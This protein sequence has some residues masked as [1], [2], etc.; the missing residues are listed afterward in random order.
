AASAKGNAHQKNK[1]GVA[2]FAKGSFKEAIACFSEVEDILR[3]QGYAT[4]SEEQTRE[5]AVALVNKARSQLFSGN[6][7]EAEADALVAARVDVN[8]CKSRQLLEE[9]WQKTGRSRSAKELAADLVLPPRTDPQKLGA[10]ISSAAKR[11][12][13]GNILLLLVIAGA[14]YVYRRP[15]FSAFNGVEEVMRIEDFPMSLQFS[16][17]FGFA[18]SFRGRVQPDQVEEC[19]VASAGVGRLGARDWQDFLYQAV[20]SKRARPGGRML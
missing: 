11:S 13:F 3:N 17:G 5:L 12:L 10:L 19:S 4:G 9:I 14:L 6:L 20:G 8:Y 18:N 16:G 2:A 15:A 1:E 7:V